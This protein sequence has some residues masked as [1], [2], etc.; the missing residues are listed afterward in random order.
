MIN[1]HTLDM[2]VDTTITQTYIVHVSFDEDATPEMIGE[3][4]GTFAPAEMEVA[5]LRP[6][7]SIWRPCMVR[8]NGASTQINEQSEALS[9]TGKDLEDHRIP[10]W[11]W[12][13]ASETKPKE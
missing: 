6:N 12:D 13:V 4:G 5:W 10:A 9:W 1:Q 11:V 3:S 8:L 7:G 2:I